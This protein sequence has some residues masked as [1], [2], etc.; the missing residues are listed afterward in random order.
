M[1]LTLVHV[2]MAEFTGVHSET[3]S[4]SEEELY[5]SSDLEDFSEESELKD[6]GDN[7]A[8]IQP[9]KF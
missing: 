8:S 2:K 1:S 7:V 9:Y 3:S 5:M 6:V 4:R